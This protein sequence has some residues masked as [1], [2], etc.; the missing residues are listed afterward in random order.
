[1]GVYRGDGPSSNVNATAGWN[2]FPEVITTGDPAHPGK[3]LTTPAT[4][5]AITP[6]LNNRPKNPVISIS[7]LLLRLI[8]NTP[9]RHRHPQAVKKRFYCHPERS[10]GSIRLI[11]NVFYVILNAVKDLE[12]VEKTK[13]FAVLLTNMEFFPSFPSSCLGTLQCRQA[14]AWPPYYA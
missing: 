6:T 14:P 5:A 9:Q 13:F 3:I 12:L 8:S 7:L 10:E 4:N 1:L 2:L 11:K